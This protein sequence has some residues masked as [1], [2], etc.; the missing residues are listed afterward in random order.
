MA[1]DVEKIYGYE[2]RNPHDSEKEW[3]ESNLNTPAMSTQDGK[4]IF[5]PFVEI[6]NKQRK[7][8][9]INE[10]SRLWMKQ[11]DFAPKF[12][13][14]I[15]QLDSFKGTPYENKPMDISHTIIGRILSND[16]SAGAITTEQQKAADFVRKYLEKRNTL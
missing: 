8:L 1:E 9:L 5:N 14:T 6:N 12:S 2:V 7:G 16:K 11:N 10:A 4:I 15:E 3:F 13:P